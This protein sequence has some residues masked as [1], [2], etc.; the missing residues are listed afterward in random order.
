M[1]SLFETLEKLGL[2][3]VVSLNDP[4]EA[5]PLARALTAG[6]LPV[7]EITFRTAAAA[8]SIRRIR[9]A[10]PDFLVG[11]GT[12]LTLE[13]AEAAAA[14]GAAFMVAPGLNPRL[15]EFCQSRGI[16]VIPGVL[17]PT[18]MEQAMSYGLTNLKLFPAEVSGGPAYIK[19][20]S[21]PYKSLR[22]MPT[23][24]VNEKN[25]KDYL[26]LPAVLCCGGTF[27]VPSAALKEGRFDEI[28][29]LTRK[30]AAIVKEVRG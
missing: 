3:P 25:V 5:L 15:V 14:A 16:P 1:S 11:A 17:T 7:A 23:G 13:Q 4:D 12:V 24:G 18:E 26:A 20:V 10:M 22:F 2:V 21:A 30:A 9:E 28:E 6:G 29:A 27:M 19:A 8:E